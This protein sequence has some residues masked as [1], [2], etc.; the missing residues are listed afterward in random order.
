MQFKW[1]LHLSKN[2]QSDKGNVVSAMNK[3]DFILL[4]MTQ[5]TIN[6]FDMQGLTDSWT[7]SK[8]CLHFLADKYTKKSIIRSSTSV[9]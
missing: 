6:V 9:Y 4:S 1:A 3:T 2:N 5:V 8:L 7:D